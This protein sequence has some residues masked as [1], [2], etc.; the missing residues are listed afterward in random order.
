M[1]DSVSKFFKTFFWNLG[2]RQAQSRALE[3]YYRIEYSNE[4]HR[5]HP[6]THIPVFKVRVQDRLGNWYYE[7][8]KITELYKDRV[9]RL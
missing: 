7:D 5:P 3:Y 8:R 6:K 4:A 9:R 1:L 2:K